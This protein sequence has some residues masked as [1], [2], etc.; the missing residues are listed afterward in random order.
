MQASTLQQVVE[1]IQEVL[2]RHGLSG[3]VDV[4]QIRTRDNFWSI[5]SELL[6][7]DRTEEWIDE[8]EVDYKAWFRSGA[9]IDERAVPGEIDQIA[10]LFDGVVEDWLYGDSDDLP[11]EQET[12]EEREQAREAL[13]EELSSMTLAQIRQH[14]PSLYEALIEAIWVYIEDTPWYDLVEG[15]LLPELFGVDPAWEYD[16]GETLAYWT[17]YFSPPSGM[18][19]EALAFR[20][21]LVPF[22]YKGRA[23]VALG[24]C[25]MDL[26]PRLDAYQA[27]ATGSL[28]SDSEFIR[29][30][31]YARAVVGDELFEA[32][33]KAVQ[34]PP[35]LHI[36]LRPR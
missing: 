17:V 13:R 10:D 23:Y 16:I 34:K 14:Y 21:G 9:E 19:D 30:P 11:I 25:G 3:Q 27:L 28:P 18:V 24:A 2:A 20:C 5:H 32:V 1:E 29:N 12:H 35:T 4:S 22:R 8:I 7:F 6:D 26:S 33:M 36:H 15:D 31:D